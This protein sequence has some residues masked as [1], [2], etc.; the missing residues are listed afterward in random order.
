MSKL[1]PRYS[2]LVPLLILIVL[3]II[4]AGLIINKP[5][6]S[7]AQSISPQ[8]NINQSNITTKDN[9][10]SGQLVDHLMQAFPQ[11]TKPTAQYLEFEALSEWLNQTPESYMGYVELKEYYDN[12]IEENTALQQAKVDTKKLQKDIHQNILE[13]TSHFEEENADTIDVYDT[14]YEVFFD[15]LGQHASLADLDLLVIHREN[16]YWMVVPRKA[17]MSQNIVDAFNATYANDSSLGEM[18][19]YH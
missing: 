5:A 18:V 14:I 4:Y 2:T 6:Q 9:I 11:L 16:P 10:M 19:I 17:Q 3:V 15:T 12:G 1:K 7:D 13:K 8:P